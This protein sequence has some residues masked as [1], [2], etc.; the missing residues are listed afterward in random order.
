VAREPACELRVLTTPSGLLASYRLRHE[1]YGALG[2]VRSPGRSGLEIDEHDR[3]AIPF[4]AF[5]GGLLIGTLRLVT[6][7][8]QPGPLRALRTLLAQL[9]DADL[10][11]AVERPRMRSLPSLVTP[12]IARQLAAFGPP[13]FPVEEL[14]RTIVRQ[15]CRGAGVSRSLMELGLALAGRG[16]PTVLVGGCLPEH[17][18]MYA[19]Y[20][21]QLLP[22]TGLDHHDSVGQLA[23]AVVCRT[24]RI[25]EPT[26]GHVDR[27]RRALA[28]GR[29]S[30]V[31]ETTPGHPTVFH[32]QG[33]DHH[34]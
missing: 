23:R 22:G 27:L 17:V 18:P 29:P 3:F 10:K 13:G 32:L 33:I 14:S 8:E 21:Y 9:G 1:V 5:R 19:R 28:A 30:C 11:R 15:G 34:A 24:D 2:Y 12:H 7:C 20:G 6:S 16:G 31:V 26:G 4:G 25:P